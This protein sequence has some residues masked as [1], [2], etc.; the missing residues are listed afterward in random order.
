M[1]LPAGSKR[2]WSTSG[3]ALW[4][5]EA[6][7]L[8]S[9]GDIIPVV[10]VETARRSSAA[11]VLVTESYYRPDLNRRGEFFVDHRA[12][13]ILDASQP[14]NATRADE[15]QARFITGRRHFVNLSSHAQVA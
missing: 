15:S 14:V 7:V 11:G 3:R 12:A 10:G 5:P 6:I 13:M 1:P 4:V 2:T 8:V 9:R